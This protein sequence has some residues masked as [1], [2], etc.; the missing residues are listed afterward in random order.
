MKIKIDKKTILYFLFFMFLIEP[1]LFYLYKTTAIVYALANLAIF[2]WFI[3]K[4]REKIDMILPI[5][6][7]IVIRVLLLVM[8]IINTNVTDLDKWGYLSLMVMSLFFVISYSIKTGEENNMIK[9]GLYLLIFYLL[10]NFVTLLIFPQGIIPDKHVYHNSDGDVYF[11]GFKVMYTSFILTTIVFCYMDKLINKTNFRTFLSIF[12]VIANLVLSNVTTGIISVAIFFI[13]Y[14]FQKHRILKISEKKLVILCLVINILV[15]FYHIQEYFSYIIVDLLGKNL[16]LTNRTYI[17]E[18]TIQQL[19]N[20][21]II[22]TILGNGIYNDGAFVSVFGNLYPAHNAWLQMIF[23]N[24]LLGT[25]LFGFMLCSF[26]NK[27][28]DKNNKFRF[29]LNSIIFSILITTI[30]SGTFSYSHTYIPF[31]F[32][33]FC[34]D[35]EKLLFDKKNNERGSI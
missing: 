22:K 14:L 34:S 17:W 11:L 4:N 30:S 1:K 18:M 21:N 25:F 8:M 6:L 33:Y 27:E 24:G 13:L 29:F 7:W 15:V 3:I 23:E 35:F 26:D 9:G 12:L 19:K 5:K 16:T 20:Q 2:G 10:I 32:L 28:T 31:V